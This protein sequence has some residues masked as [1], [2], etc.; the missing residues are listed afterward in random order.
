MLCVTGG[1]TTK[2]INPTSYPFNRNGVD[3]LFDRKALCDDAGCP[4]GA[5]IADFKANW[6]CRGTEK[7]DPEYQSIG[8]K[9][10]IQVLRE[11]GFHVHQPNSKKFKVQPDLVALLE[12]C[13]DFECKDLITRA[14]VTDLMASHGYIALFGVKYHAEVAWVERKWM[15]VKRLIRPRLN[16][17]LPR[18]KELLQKHWGKF[19]IFDSWKAARHYR[20]SMRAYRAISDADLDTIRQEGLKMK[21]HRRVFDGSVGKYMLQLASPNGADSTSKIDDKSHRAPPAQ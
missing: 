3:T 10:L 17:K 5:C 14:H 18:L 21:V 6:D 8:V 1:K 4:T 16:G 13:S 11:R 2:D 12:T 15:H 7:Y 19:T 20:D 9:G